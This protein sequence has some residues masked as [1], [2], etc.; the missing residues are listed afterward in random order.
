[1]PMNDDPLAPDSDGFW[2]AIDQRLIDLDQGLNWLD[3]NQARLALHDL[4]GSMRMLGLSDLAALATILDDGFQVD[5]RAP[6]RLD[7]LNALQAAVETAKAAGGHI[8]MVHA[9][10]HTKR[11]L[12]VAE[13]AW[14]DALKAAAPEGWR[15][16]IAKDGRTVRVWLRHA[17]LRVIVWDPR[18]TAGNADSWPELVPPGV[19]ILQ[20][21]P[22][23]DAPPARVLPAHASAVEIW[24]QV[25]ATAR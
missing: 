14:A 8:P 22:D 3:L 25:S 23:A 1:M 9:A 16:S 18:M 4:A 11:L 17:D 5:P 15:V 2:Q 20:L 19:P 12:V 21:G 10:R 6:Q 13:G 7:E 24:D